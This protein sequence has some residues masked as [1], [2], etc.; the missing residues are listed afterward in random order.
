[1]I[2]T[3]SKLAVKFF[4][5]FFYF[6]LHVLRGG[7]LRQRRFLGRSAT[8]L[9]RR[10]EKREVGKFKRLKIFHQR[11][12]VG[13]RHRAVIAAR[14]LESGQCFTW[15]RVAFRRLLGSALRPR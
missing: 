3:V 11:P 13:P 7:F 5:L 4:S 14:L 1:M 9:T 10:V 2:M 12:Y 6:F 8:V 15:H